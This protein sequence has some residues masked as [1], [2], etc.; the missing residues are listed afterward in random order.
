MQIVSWQN[1]LQKISKKMNCVGKY[2][3]NLLYVSS[4]TMTFINYHVTGLANWTLLHINHTSSS[5][6]KH[7]N[8]MPRL[9]KHLCSNFLWVCPFAM[10][11]LTPLPA[12]IPG[13]RTTGSTQIPEVGKHQSISFPRPLPLAVS[14]GRFYHFLFLH[15]LSFFILLSSLHVCVVNDLWTFLSFFSCSWSVDQKLI[16]W[17][18]YDKS[19]VKQD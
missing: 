18:K 1:V 5:H 14:L 11:Y 19:G 16:L 13:A 6:G 10:C 17:L 12:K 2:P 8:R 4:L 15:S 7:E 9:V 3:F